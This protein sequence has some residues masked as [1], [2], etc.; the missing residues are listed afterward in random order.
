MPSSRAVIIGAGI[1][2]LSAAVDLACDGVDVLVLERASTLGGKLRQI[3]ISGAAIDAGPT[4]FTMKWVFEELFEKANQRLNDH[5]TLHKAETIARHAWGKDQHL[6][7]FADPKQSADAIADF[8]G[9]KD[10]A[11]Y[12]RFV[13]DAR[14][15]YDTL[16]EP[17]IKD[18]KPHMRQ[19]VGRITAS[20]PSNLLHLNPFGSLWR[21]LGSY[22]RDPRLQ[23]LFGRYATYCGSSPYLAS[24]V[25]MLV[26]SVEQQGVWIVEGGMHRIAD[27]L[28]KILEGRGGTIRTDTHVDEIIV[29]GGAASGVRLANGEVI[30]ADIVV[31]N[32]DVNAIASGLFGDTVRQAAPGTALKD[33][34]LSA[35]TWAMVARTDGFPLLH[36]N[37]FFTSRYEREFHDI[38][39]QKQLPREPTVYICAQ[40][41]SGDNHTQPQGAE[42]LFII[43]NAPPTGDIKTFGQKEIDSCAV[44][45]FETLSRC[46]LRIEAEPQSSVVTTPTDFHRMFPATGGAIYG[47]ASHGWQAA[48]QRAP[49]R[50]RIPGLYFAGGSVHPGSGLPM[51]ALSGRLAAQAV[52]E[53]LASHKK[54]HPAAT[55][56]GM[57]TD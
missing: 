50:S 35:M 6:D 17:F 15:I 14:R 42:R 27:A 40:D 23:Q 12:L 30:E 47:Q 51:A 49:S 9:P 37:V 32:S 53:D 29:T 11:G 3:R 21:K 18:T 38:F 31:A 52:R 45:L 19:L 5:L 20:S 2:G 7:L 25:L 4:V 48:F 8:S 28:A 56:G 26:A 16:E 55:P 46:G 1:G 36:H 33:R 54:S 57:S 43:V 44:S 39:R 24:A 22:F 41:R 10:A 34:S 13:R